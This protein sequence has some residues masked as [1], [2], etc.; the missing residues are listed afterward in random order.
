M[1]LDPPP[2]PGLTRIG[3]ISALF[4]A[5]VSI[6]AWSFNFT[7]AKYALKHGFN[8]LSYTAPRFLL[9]SLAFMVLALPRERT[10]RVSRRE[11]WL[12]AAAGVVGIWLNQMAFVFALDHTSATT[13][14]LL[15]GTLPIFVGLLSHVSK[16]ERMGQRQ[17]LAAVVSCAGAAMVALGAS[18]V[19]STDWLGIAFALGMPLTWAAYSVGVAPLLRRYSS[20]RINAIVC[21]IGTLPLVLSSIPDLQRQDWSAPNALAW[22]ALIYGALIAY[23]LATSVWFVVVRG[24][25]VPRAAL[26]QNLMPFIGA[27]FA[28]VLLS[29][30]LTLLQ[31]AGGVVIGAGIAIAWRARSPEPA[32]VHVGVKQ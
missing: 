28:L 16:R 17:W 7:A 31:I 10:L 15:F 23:V 11:L 21:S 30:P 20:L 12:L 2:C 22:S 9:A 4:L 8:P 19:V 6:T 13:V 1:V 18:R 27:I 32:L 5:V 14:A 29:E 26:Y 25:G 3:R 24:I